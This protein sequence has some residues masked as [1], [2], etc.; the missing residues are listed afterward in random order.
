M[1][2]W[3]YD[4]A[5]GRQEKRS[6]ITRDLKGG[7]GSAAAALICRKLQISN[8]FFASTELDAS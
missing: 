5:R 6:F 4:Q 3:G 1:K 7:Q 8:Q 2:A